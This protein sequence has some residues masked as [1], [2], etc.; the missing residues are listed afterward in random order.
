[1]RYARFEGQK[2]KVMKSHQLLATQTSE[3]GSGSGNR[4]DVKLDKNSLCSHYST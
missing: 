4:I 1:V 3:V 2:V